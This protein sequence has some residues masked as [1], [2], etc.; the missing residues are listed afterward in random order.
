MTLSE[1]LTVSGEMGHFE[2]KVRRNPRYIDPE[3]CIACGLCAE[4]CPKKVTDEFNMG[5]GWRKAAYIRYSQAV[6]LKYAIDQA[7]CIY[8][9][10]GKCRACEKFCPT[11]A[12]NFDDQPQERVIRVGAIIVSTGFNASDP[13]F[14]NAYG[15][16]RHPNVITSLEFERML[17]ASG[18]Y[19]GHVVRP[20]DKQEAKKIAWLQCV[21]SRDTHP[22]A[23]SYCSSVCC[24]Y[25]VKEAVMAKDH[26]P[27]L[28]AAIF[29]MDIRTH[30][31]DFERYYNHARSK[32]GVRFVKS[33]IPTL[34]FNDHE[35]L[36]IRY[37][38]ETGQRVEEQ[39][40][41]VVLSVGL[42]QSPLGEQLLRRLNI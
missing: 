20:S 38:N 18:P 34:G 3:K 10:K 30:G 35:D 6:P 40:D 42:N 26:V 11:G 27:G 33:R 25:A 31:K 13:S 17:S 24:T 22:G 2:V 14:F 9:Q 15:Y 4:K 37:Y 7:N 32:A 36:S 1:I 8:L 5:L 16:G 19:Q 23:K 39:F 29:Y 28:D 41:I 21:G 12:I